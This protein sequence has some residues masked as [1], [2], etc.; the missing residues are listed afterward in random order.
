M[1][2]IRM[3]LAQMPQFFRV[4]EEVCN[5]FCQNQSAIGRAFDAVQNTWRDRN[6]AVAGARLTDTARDIA[7]FYNSL[8]EAVEYVLRVCNNRA[9]YVDYNQLTPPQIDGFTI[10]ITEVNVDNS[11]INTDP[12]ALDE[13]KTALDKYIQS[14]V[15]NVERLRKLY[16]NIGS[17]WD[18]EQY[19]KFG[20]ELAAFSRQM[21]AQVDIL[22]RISAFLKNRIE[23]LRRG[24]I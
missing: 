9:E 1:S 11:V 23:I 10:N 14:I 18:D 3:D 5:S 21:Q 19:R 13:F 22:D 6:A 12:D 7:K 2:H 8:C 24:D 17:S 4:T 15:D 16:S 20:D